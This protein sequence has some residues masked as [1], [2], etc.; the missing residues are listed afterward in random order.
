MRVRVEILQEARVSHMTYMVRRILC[1]TRNI[2]CAWHETHSIFVYT[3]TRGKRY[4]LSA[5]RHAF[6]CVVVSL[7]V[8]DWLGVWDTLA[9]EMHSRRDTA[10]IVCMYTNTHIQIQTHI[11]IH[12]HYMCLHIYT[13][14]C[15]CIYT[16]IFT[17]AYT[18]LHVHMQIHTYKIYALVYINTYT[19]M[20]IYI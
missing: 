20:Y 19:W 16:Y 18:Y 9:R 14:I 10:R 15:T 5:T 1:A 3:N 17:C 2:F 11:Q 8:C 13:Y 6:E 4:I 12:T 7:C